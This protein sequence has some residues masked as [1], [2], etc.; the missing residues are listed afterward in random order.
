TGDTARAAE[1]LRAFWLKEPLSKGLETAIL[2]R[3]GTLLT[4]ADHKARMEMLLYRD[5][6]DQAARFG[7]LGKAQSL[8]RAWAAVIRKAKTADAL[9]AAVDPSWHKDP[10]YTFLRIRHLRNKEAYRAAGKLFA[11]MPDD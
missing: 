7:D 11:G 8:F 3:F 1:I 10:A 4:P 6:L 9:I 5:R 2:D